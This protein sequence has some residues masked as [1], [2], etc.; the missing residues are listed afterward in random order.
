MAKPNYQADTKTAM[1][2]IELDM[3][4]TANAYKVSRTVTGSYTV[5]SDDTTI[6]VNA[7]AGAVITLPS[8]KSSI[9]PSAIASSG[10]VVKEYAIINSGSVSI[11]IQATGGALVNG[12]TSQTLTAGSMVRPVTDGQAW[13]M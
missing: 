7:G 3:G 8:P 6:F 12:A 9:Q 2:K 5:T 1:R 11:T 13:H 4:A 10:H